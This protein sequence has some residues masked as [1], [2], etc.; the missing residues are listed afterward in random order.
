MPVANEPALN[1]GLVISPI[2]DL[3]PSLTGVVPSEPPESVVESSW[4]SSL[5]PI[6][7]D[8]LQPPFN[9]GGEVD[10]LDYLL[11]IGFCAEYG[12]SCPVLSRWQQNLGMKVHG[13]PAE[14]DIATLL[15]TIEELN[16]LIPHLNLEITDKNPNLNIH[17]AQVQFYLSRSI[18]YFS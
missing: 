13:E 5:L 7:R 14:T 6:S 12:S 4:T 15:Q 2:P 16:S 9:S 8:R 11:E 1:V 18:I 10:A 3:E 17:F